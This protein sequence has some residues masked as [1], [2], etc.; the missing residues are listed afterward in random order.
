[1]LIT[2]EDEE[3]EIEK[4]KERIIYSTEYHLYL[5]YEREEEGDR[6]RRKAMKKMEEHEE[7]GNEE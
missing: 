6:R 5:I 7:Q 2:D 3:N 1:M 4:D